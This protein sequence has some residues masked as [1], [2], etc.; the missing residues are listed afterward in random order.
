MGTSGEIFST[1]LYYDEIDKVFGMTPVCGTSET[2][3]L[4]VRKQVP[5]QVE[6]LNELNDQ[7]N[8]P[9]PNSSSIITQLE[10]EILD[11]STSESISDT[12]ENSTI[13]P[14]V[15]SSINV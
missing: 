15:S 2:I 8:M 14:L 12:I 4:G 3:S 13:E 11:P 6:F 1:L 9:T 7:E 5:L 10:V